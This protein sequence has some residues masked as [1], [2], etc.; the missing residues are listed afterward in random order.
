MVSVCV[1]AA[2]HVTRA[3]QVVVETPPTRLGS[4]SPGGEGVNIYHNVMSHV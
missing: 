1:G 4:D 2:G 3:T